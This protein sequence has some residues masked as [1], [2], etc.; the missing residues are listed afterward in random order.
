MVH[1]CV[2]PQTSG[3][4]TVIEN[5]FLWTLKMQNN[6]KILELRTSTD[7]NLSRILFEYNNW[8]HTR[9]R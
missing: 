8:A 2:Q 4:E 7:S 1:Y 6:N 5:Y 9:Q 3:F